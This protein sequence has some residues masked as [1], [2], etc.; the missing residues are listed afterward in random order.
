MVIWSE[1]EILLVHYLKVSKLIFQCVEI[2]II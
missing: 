2:I 1:Q